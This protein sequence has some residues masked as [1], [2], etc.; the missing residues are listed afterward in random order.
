[1]PFSTELLNSGV[2]SLSD[3]MWYPTAVVVYQ[4]MEPG[5]SIDFTLVVS[6]VDDRDQ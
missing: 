4:V 6:S 3:D 5:I 1:M 2:W